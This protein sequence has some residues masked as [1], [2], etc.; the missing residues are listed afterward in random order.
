MIPNHVDSP[1]FF[2]PPKMFDHIG[3]QLEAI[4]GEPNLPQP[5]QQVVQMGV[6]VL[7]S[8][9]A[10]QNYAV[11]A[12]KATLD[13][14]TAFEDRMQLLG[15]IATATQFFAENNEAALNFFMTTL[16][17][18]AR[19]LGDQAGPVFEAARQLVATSVGGIQTLMKPTTAEPAALPQ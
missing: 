19:Y 16:Q 14:T 7:C 2:M 4:S 15:R 5:I 18:E 10:V 13:E 8:S 9:I 1:L 3:Q 6:S 12:L 11:D 17:D